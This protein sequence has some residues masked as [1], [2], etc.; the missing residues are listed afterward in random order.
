MVR[1]KYKMHK[2]LNIS[3]GCFRYGNTFTYNYVTKEVECDGQGDDRMYW[4]NI[5]QVLPRLFYQISSN[6]Y[7]LLITNKDMCVYLVIVFART[8]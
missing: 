8:K 4:L 3:K 7:N 2:S 5:E 6:Y 1:L